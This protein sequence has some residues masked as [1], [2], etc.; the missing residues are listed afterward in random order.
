MDRISNMDRW[1]HNIPCRRRDGER[2]AQSILQFVHLVV[3]VMIAVAGVAVLSALAHGQ[4]RR[5]PEVIV[6]RLPTCAPCH[7]LKLD[8]QEG[9]LGPRPM[10]F[11]DASQESDISREFEA[12]VRPTNQT[13]P[14]G[15]VGQV[16]LRPHQIL[17]PVVWVRGSTHFWQGYTVQH[18]AALK[19]YLD[20]NTSPAAQ[21]AGP[22]RPPSPASVAQVEDFDGVQI[23][24]ACA[25][26]TESVPELRSEAARRAQ[27]VLEQLAQTHIGQQVR[28]SFIAEIADPDRFARVCNAVGMTP[29]PAFCL[30]L[31]PERLSGV[32]GLLVGRVH[33]A[34]GEH[35]LVP[36]Q[37]A[38]VHV[39]LER[40]HGTTYDALLDVVLERSG[41][42]SDPYSPGDG[43]KFL[44]AAWLGE[45]SNLARRLLARFGLATV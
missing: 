14:N 26:L 2:A 23:V 6:F 1:K 40:L 31:V 25:R 11:I 3:I 17:L 45:R 15:Y 21:P 37:Q 33:A 20:R 4:D 39:I 22:R 36:L 30:V 7:A 5:Q 12:T 38:G 44:A 8:V 13:V 9:R 16:N 43:M 19:E 35:F 28:A 34:L 27:R 41:T 18:A 29:A 32:K 24:V 10:R 42:P